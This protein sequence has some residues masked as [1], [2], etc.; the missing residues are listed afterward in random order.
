MT[1]RDCQHWGFMGKCAVQS[2]MRGSGGVRWHQLIT[3]EP[4]ESCESFAKRG[5]TITQGEP[6]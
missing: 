2:G 1:C 4:H 6:Q 5:L 3:T